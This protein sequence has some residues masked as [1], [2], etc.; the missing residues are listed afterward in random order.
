MTYI[1][2]YNET[3]RDLLTDDSG[4]LDLRE[5]GAGNSVVSGARTMEISSAEQVMLLLRDGNRRRTQEAT[6]AN[7]TSSRSH[8][9]L[10]VVARQTSLTADCTQVFKCGRLFMC[11]LAG[12]ERAANTKN[13]GIRMVEGTLIP[14]FT[15]ARTLT[16]TLTL[17]LTLTLTLTLSL[18]PTPTLTQP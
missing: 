13:S 2:I 5:D 9:I 11:D 18:T 7:A 8:A 1:E 17:S 14:T 16:R 6:A 12:S 15:L 10:E 4:E 3:L